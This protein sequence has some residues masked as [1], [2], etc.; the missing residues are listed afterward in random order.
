[1]KIIA[2]AA[3][4]NKHSINRQLA[5]YAA[6]LVEG[7]EIEVLDLNDYEMPIYSE[8]REEQYW[9]PAPAR[10]FH[11]RLRE[12]DG[13]VVS[14]AEHNGTY[15]AAWKNLFDWISRVDRKPFKDKPM[16]LLSTSPGSGGASSVLEQA[17]H[18]IPHFGGLV[19]ASVSVPDFEDN[20]DKERQQVSKWHLRERLKDAAQRLFPPGWNSR[21]AQ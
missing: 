2:F 4:N 1:M 16:L 19:Q 7:A 6:G 13:I 11:A 8:Q 12:A 3:S 21:W 5:A 9:Q 15:T 18:H 14:F 20:F 17:V 10:E